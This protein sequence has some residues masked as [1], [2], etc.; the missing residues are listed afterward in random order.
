MATCRLRP[1]RATTAS[2]RRTAPQMLAVLDAIGTRIG[3]HGPAS[4]RAGRVAPGRAT[5]AAAQFADTS[6]QPTPCAP[7]SGGA[8]CRHRASPVRLTRC[9]NGVLC[10]C[11]AR[12]RPHARVIPSRRWR[13]RAAG[14]SIV[15]QEAFGLCRFAGCTTVRKGA[16]PCDRVNRQPPQCMALHSQPG[17][18]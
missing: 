14:R 2:A 13:A 8:H 17:E 7:A 6:R 11:S 3:H 10:L 12:A 9:G 16:D 1:L 5:F 4:A 18:R 15:R